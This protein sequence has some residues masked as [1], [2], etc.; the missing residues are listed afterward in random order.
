MRKLLHLSRALSAVIL[1]GCLALSPIVDRSVVGQEEGK[2]KQGKTDEAEKAN[3]A[4]KA[5]KPKEAKQAKANQERARA[6]AA[7]D[8]AR[9]EQ[10]SRLF[11]AMRESWNLESALEKGRGELGRNQS[12]LAEASKAANAAREAANA[13]PDDKPKADKAAAATDA[14]K[15]ATEAVENAKRQVAEQSGKLN[16]AMDTVATLEA[17]LLGGLKLIPSK[18]WDYEKARHLLA[19]AGFGGTP[20]EIQALVDMGMYKAVQYVVEYHERPTAN[21][22]LD[23]RPQSRGPAYE[24]YLSG[25]ARQELQQRQRRNFR[26]QIADMRKWWI[27]RMV[28]SPRPLEEKLTLFW[29]DH[30]AVN[31]R[32]FNDPYLVHSQ[33]QLFRRYADQ[34]NGLLHGIVQD[35]AMIRYLDNH[36]NR[37]GNG[38][39]NLG[40]ELQE[41]FSIGEENSANHK[42]NGYSENDVR[43]AS[44]ALTGYTYDAPTGQFRFL[45][46]RY[47]E[48]PK[49][50]LG[51]KGNWSGDEVV[52]ILLQHPSTANYVSKK[53]FEFFVHRNP[54]PETIDAIAHVLRSN[55]YELRPMLRN[56]F[57]SEEFYGAEARAAHIKSPAEL[58]VG[59]IKTL[60]IKDVDYARI[61]AA[62]QTAGHALFEPPNV[63]GWDEG[64]AWITSKQLL[65][66]YNFVAE[67]VDQ[68]NVDIL[69]TL[70]DGAEFRSAEEVVDHLIRRCLVLDIGADKRKAMIDFL[71]EIPPSS[72]WTVRRDE[73][74]A[75]LKAIVVMLLGSPEYQ[76][77]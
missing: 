69:A 71:G 5:V 20:S 26:N 31:F 15:Q 77:S 9:R 16:E 48:T 75:R 61:D 27:R 36:T 73:I 49:D 67:L 63:A 37:K 38:N 14:E 54:K 34:F 3:D 22:E 70:T 74:N 21:L 2:P 12:R 52:D 53:L 68:R 65:D 4:P 57:M 56:L 30:F 23:V 13:A 8:A 66:R 11:D 28:E 35:P 40:R 55:N 50:V 24:Q 46:S 72:E 58:M 60:G 6:R 41:L 42:P 45:G 1:G 19:R 33:N 76:V 47:D 32:D 51:K 18:D 39:E 17:D 29:H 7:N 25:M 64:Q 44:R 62:C 10:A 59:T 43:E